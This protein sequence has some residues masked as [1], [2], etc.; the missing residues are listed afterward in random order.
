[1]RAKNE[2]ILRRKAP[3]RIDV[4]DGQ[5]RAL[6]SHHAS[7]FTMESEAWPFHKACW[8]AVGRGVIQYS[9]ETVDIQ[10]DD[11]LLIPADTVHR[12]VDAPPEPLTLIM[13]CISPQQI[14]QEHDPGSNDLWKALFS[15]KMLKH[16]FC[17]KKRFPLRQSA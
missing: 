15:N 16:P 14:S 12:F 13:L 17:A 10:K 3:V 2:G 6:E 5:V 11:F 8:V 7:D 1:M 9:E 4:P